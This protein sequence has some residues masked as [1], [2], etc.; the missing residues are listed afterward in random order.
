MADFS[1]FE[2]LKQFGASLSD[3][4]ATRLALLAN[5]LHEE[6]LRLTQ[7]LL[8][9]LIALFCLGVAVLLSTAFLVV[10]FWDSHRLLVIGLLTG[11]FFA[12]GG[13]MLWLLRAQVRQKPKLF[14]ASLAELDKDKA[15]L[16]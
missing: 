10:L 16:Q 9:T 1:L 6:R 15:A 14:A 12:V 13:V 8:F 11:L 5:E 7:M 4:A 3:I 2:A